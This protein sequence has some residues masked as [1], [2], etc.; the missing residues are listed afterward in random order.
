M[1]VDGKKLKKLITLYGESKRYEEKSYVALFCNDHGLSYN[2]WNAYLRGAQNLGTKIIQQLI[3]IFPDLNLNW[4]LKD[5]PNIFISDKKEHILSEP[6]AKYGKP[7]TT[8]DLM[9]KLEELHLDVKKVLE[10]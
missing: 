4:L 3:D 8:K 5:E 9:R 10:K 6:Q 1:Y 2:Q 7:V